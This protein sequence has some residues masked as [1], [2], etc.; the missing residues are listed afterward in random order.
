MRLL[1]AR[2][3]ETLILELHGYVFFGTAHAL[4]ARIIRA[5]EAP[6]GTVRRVI[7]DCR[8][9]QGLD[10]SATFSFARLE[11]LFRARGMRL[12]V[13]G[14]GEGARAPLERVGLL[15]RVRIF[16][17]L[18]AALSVVEEE[19]LAE[20]AAAAAPAPSPVAE[21]LARAEALGA[22]VPAVETVAAGTEVLRQGEAADAL[23][24]IEAGLLSARVA[25]ADGHATTVARFQPG[26]VV[27]EIALYAGGARTATVVADV[28]SRVRRLTRDDLAAISARDPAFA[29]DL[30]AAI[31]ALL[32]MRLAR[33]TGLLHE[34]SR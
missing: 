30:H 15:E 24:L 5:I 25:G 21:L 33:T 10:V 20:E 29:R 11:E 4:T 27:G 13:T 22:A 3:A 14:L 32:A 19:V 6:G 2:G 8:R 34:M 7:L 12:I 26:T 16:P 9:V 23:V 1:A 28:A 31:A 18:D 17:T